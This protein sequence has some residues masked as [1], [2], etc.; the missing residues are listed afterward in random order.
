MQFNIFLH[1]IDH[2]ISGFEL[3]GISIKINDKEF[4][5]E[6]KKPDQSMMIFIALS[7]L[8]NGIR[9]IWEGKGREFRFVGA[10]SSFTILFRKIKNNVLYLIQEKEIA[11]VDFKQFK[12]EL[13]FAIEHFYLSYCDK[14][15][16]DDAAIYDLKNSL[17]NYKTNIM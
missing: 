13:Y 3:G 10:D 11:E 12:D 4:S 5:S 9:Y 14:I 2:A 6:N 1:P 17:N 7:D 15:A 16:S 8:L